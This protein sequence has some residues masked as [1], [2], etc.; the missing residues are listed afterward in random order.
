MVLLVGLGL[1]ELTWG[2]L[3]YFLVEELGPVLTGILTGIAPVFAV[4]G[5]VLIW[6][7]RLNA[8]AWLDAGAALAGV[9]IASLGGAA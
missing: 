1:M 3:F 7:E 4:L 2:V 9:F 5:G 6:K 8:L